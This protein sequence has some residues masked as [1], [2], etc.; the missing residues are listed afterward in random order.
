MAATSA[1]IHAVVLLGVLGLCFQYHR[2]VSQKNL[3]LEL[4]IVD[5][6]KLVKVDWP[7]KF[8]VKWAAALK[9][10]MVVLGRKHS[11]KP[12]RIHFE[13]LRQ[14]LLIAPIKGAEL[15]LMGQK[16][17]LKLLVDNQID[18]QM[19]SKRLSD[20]LGVSVSVDSSIV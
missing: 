7:S 9:L 10:D 8:I 12:I 13:P 20:A 19:W 5:K 18:G 1:I 14:F 6:T 11:T 4:F 2:V 17:E 3:L 16:P 15:N